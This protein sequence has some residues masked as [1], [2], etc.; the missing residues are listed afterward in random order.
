MQIGCGVYT[1][2]VRGKRYLYY[3]HYESRG[4][5]RVQVKEYLGPVASQ[6]ARSDATERCEGYFARAADDLERLKVATLGEIRAMG[7]Q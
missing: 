4:G 2:T 3:W 7:A 1:Q 5:S 6:R